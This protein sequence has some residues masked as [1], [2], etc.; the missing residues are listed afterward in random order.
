MSPRWLILTSVVAALVAPG[1]VTAAVPEGQPREYASACKTG[2]LHA[3]SLPHR[4]EPGRCDLA[5]RTVVFRGLRTTMPERGHGTSLAG[6]IPGGGEDSLDITTSFAGVTTIR[7]T[8]PRITP[9]EQAER[10]PIG[11]ATWPAVGTPATPPPNDNFA[12]AMA[13]RPGDQYLVDGLP[14]ATLEPGEPTPTCDPGA[15]VSVWYRINPGA[16]HRLKIFADD[17]AELWQGDSLDELT[18]IACST[19]DEQVALLPLHGPFYIQETSDD[20]PALGGVSTRSGEPSD[21]SPLPCK[22]K[23]YAIK[24]DLAPRKPFTYRINVPGKASDQRAA[25][26]VKG[27]KRGVRVITMSKNDCGIPDQ[28]NARATYG[29][30]TPKHA[31]LCG[32]HPWSASDKVNTM[33]VSN[34][35]VGGYIALTCSEKTSPDME[36]WKV[37][38]ADTAFSSGWTLDPDNPDCAFAYDLIGVTAHETGHAF[39]LD[40]APGANLTMA[41][42]GPACNGALSSLGR[43]DVLALRKLY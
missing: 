2:V 10:L 19:T 8:G 15:A 11:A 23:R 30:L 4:I 34:R 7:A 17:A 29:G 35:W 20:P 43:G 40:H 28:V 25:D 31:T 41:A 36:H 14:L 24:D 27:I 13:I 39:I 33:E 12:D 37:V 42:S 9:G 16:L 3:A 22:D 6:L 26:F 21:L 1:G 18:P 32:P 5:G 38:E